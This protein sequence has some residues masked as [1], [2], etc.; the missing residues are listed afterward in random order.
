MY[1]SD[2]KTTHN[3]VTILQAHQRDVIPFRS[4]T[5]I[6]KRKAVFTLAYEVKYHQLNNKTDS[7]RFLQCTLMTQV[8]LTGNNNNSIDGK[9][10]RFLVYTV[11]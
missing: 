11:D 3:D 2:M 4:L 8:C 6:L 10:Q 9:D 7:A 1:S 5:L